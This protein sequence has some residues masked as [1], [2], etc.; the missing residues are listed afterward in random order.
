M[1][2]PPISCLAGVVAAQVLFST[3]YALADKAAHDMYVLYSCFSAV[4][5]EKTHGTQVGKLMGFD[6]INSSFD[7]I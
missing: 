2:R 5:R 7:G 1:F 4:L 6:V 3:T